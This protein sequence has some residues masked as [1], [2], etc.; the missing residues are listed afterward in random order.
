MKKYINVIISVIG[1]VIDII[2]KKGERKNK[3]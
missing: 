1:E 3:R 2:L